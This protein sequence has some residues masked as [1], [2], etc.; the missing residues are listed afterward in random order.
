M[1]RNYRLP[2]IAAV[3][4]ALL[5]T[6]SLIQAQPNNTHIQ[7]K[8]AQ[9]QSAAVVAPAPIEKQKS[10]R[11][12]AQTESQKNAERREIENLNAQTR[13]ADAAWK[14]VELTKWQN[15]LIAVEATLLAITIFF[16]GWAAW[17]A[18]EGTRKAGEAIAQS[19]RHARQQLRAYMTVTE[20]NCESGQE[21]PIEFCLTLKNTGQ[22][23]AYRLRVKDGAMIAVNEPAR[24]EIPLSS[25]DD[26]ETVLGPGDTCEHHILKEDTMKIVGLSQIK[27]IRDG[28]L[29]FFIEGIIEYVDAFKNPQWTTFRYSYGKDDVLR[30]GVSFCRYSGD[31]S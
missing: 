30:E 24:G 4:L 17:A 5:V 19:E 9:E 23:P 8:A 15:R 21:W 20:V 29:T 16:T 25:R 10:A 2:I 26:Y 18:S 28:T 22:T 31:A 3:G 13:M 27:E 7:A 11:T 14:Q 12:E 6:H 1:S